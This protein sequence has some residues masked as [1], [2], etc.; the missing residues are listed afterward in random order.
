MSEAKDLQTQSAV[1]GER[2]PSGKRVCEILKTRLGATL[3]LNRPSQAGE[4]RKR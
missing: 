2:I 3:S 1:E 4:K